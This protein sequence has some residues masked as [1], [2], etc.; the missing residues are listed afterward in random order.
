MSAELFDWTKEE[1]AETIKFAKFLKTNKFEVFEINW[2]QI[3]KGKNEQKTNESP[4]REKGQQNS[5]RR[6]FYYVKSIP[7]FLQLSLPQSLS[8]IAPR[9]S[10]FVCAKIQQAIEKFAKQICKRKRCSNALSKWKREV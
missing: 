8:F 9:V 3:A 7:K 1:L 5:V 4:K 10:S 2:E 6:H